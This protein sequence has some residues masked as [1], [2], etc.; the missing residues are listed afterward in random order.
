[1]E[2]CMAREQATSIGAYKTIQSRVESVVQS[3]VQSSSKLTPEQRYYRFLFES[4]YK[5]CGQLVPYFW[6][7]KFVEATDASARTLA[8]YHSAEV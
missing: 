2:W 6:M 5:S 7:P 8:M 1:M 4:Y 3:N